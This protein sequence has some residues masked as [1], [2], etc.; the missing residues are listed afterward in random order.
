MPP[1]FIWGHLVPRNLVP[2]TSRATPVPRHWA[3]AFH[4]QPREDTAPRHY[5]RRGPQTSSELLD[6]PASSTME[7][8][9]LLSINYLISEIYEGQRWIQTWRETHGQTGT[10]HSSPMSKMDTDWHAWALWNGTWSSLFLWEL[11][12]PRTNSQKD[13][14]LW[15]ETCSSLSSTKY[16][17]IRLQ[18]LKKNHQGNLSIACSPQISKILFLHTPA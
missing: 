17:S 14:S 3:L 16:G 18:G 13:A 6:I 4:C 5:L 7:N 12:T 11:W 10:L 8:V 15:Q 9:C 1:A 2:L